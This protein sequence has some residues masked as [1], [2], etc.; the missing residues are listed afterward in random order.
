MQ[1]LSDRQ[2]S[3]ITRLIRDHHLAFTVNILGKSAVSDK[4]FQRLVKS[5][6]VHSS[7]TKSLPQD[8]F[9]FGELSDAL[10][11]MQ[12]QGMDYTTFKKYVA[13]HPVALGET[14]RFAVKHLRRSFANHIGSIA[15]DMVKS[16]NQSIVSGDQQLQRK[17]ASTVKSALISGIE[18]RKTV[19]EIARDLQRHTKDYA[20][21]W[22]RTAS[23][24]MNNAFQEGKAQVILKAAGADYDP[25]VFKRPR[26]DCCEECVAHY[27]TKSGVPRLFKLSELLAHGTNVGRN[28]ELRKSVVGSHHPWCQCEL[29]EM[30]AGFEFDKRG[31]MTYVGMGA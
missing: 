19:Q 11:E 4:D 20:H 6:Y 8:A 17:L 14:E 15:D 29:H 27:L 31:N 28:K 23:T 24:E 25:T 7:A 9:T 5:G 16:V 22:L 13:S 3:E 2:V 26:P 12:A 10:K 21:D 30:P 18:K 1:A